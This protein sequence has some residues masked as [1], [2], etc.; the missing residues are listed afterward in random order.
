VLHGGRK[1]PRIECQGQRL[2]GKLRAGR[3]D[4]EGDGGGKGLT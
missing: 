2:Q 4:R 3:G 1:K